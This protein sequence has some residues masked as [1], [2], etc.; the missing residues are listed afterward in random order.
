MTRFAVSK[1]VPSTLFEVGATATLALMGIDDHCLALIVT[2]ARA[3]GCAL[4]KARCGT[5]VI[6]PETPRFTYVTLVMF[7][8]LRMMVVL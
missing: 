6:A 8:S 2:A 5:A 7:V 3:T 1:R 4:T